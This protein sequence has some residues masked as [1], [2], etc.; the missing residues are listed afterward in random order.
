MLGTHSA[1]H[2]QGH[3]RKLVE[4]GLA[5]AQ[6]DH[7]PAVVVA[8]DKKETFYQRCGFWNLVGWATEGDDNPLRVFGVGGG[9]IL[10]NEG[11]VAAKEG[12][13]GERQ[14]EKKEE[15]GDYVA[16]ESASASAIASM[17]ASRSSTVSSFEVVSGVLDG[18]ESGH[19]S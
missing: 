9:A 5:R 6:A 8:A 18:K 12:V 19:G 16:G 13:A 1:S 17:S 15:E 7:L 14:E 2:G 4:A 10:W 11:P 3:G